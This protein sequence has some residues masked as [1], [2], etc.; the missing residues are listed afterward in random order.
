M[1]FSRFLGAAFALAFASTTV[2]ADMLE[3]QNVTD[4]IYAL[5]GP[6]EQRSAENLA[7]NATFGVVVTDEGV[8]LMDPG[9]SWKGAQAIHNRIREITDQPVKFV[10]NTGGQ[11]HRWLGNG[12]WQSHG[13]TVIAS[14]AAVEDHKARG[15][16]QLTALSQFLGD[17]LSDTEAAY[18]DV[19]FAD[20]YTLEL[21]GLTFEIVHPGQAHTP[22][23]SFVWLDQKDTVFTGDIVYVERILGNGGQSNAKSWIEAFE[24]MAA[25]EPV[26]VVPGHGHAT[27]LEHATADTYDYLVNLRT[28]IGALIEEG[29]DIM[30]APNI[31]QSTFE[32][33]EQF[34]SLAGRNAQTTY[35][36]MEWE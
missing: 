32:Y 29:G 4:G 5:V 27:T 20:T 8:V 12:Y 17:Q 22:G 16:Q 28:Q 34:D 31:D 9:G 15:S 35:E 11:D 23:D 2:Q 10:I 26:H 36:Q 30:D 18:A 24:A 7:N 25:L 14:Q 21:G 6:K 1:I 3:V 13:A 19:T 33:L